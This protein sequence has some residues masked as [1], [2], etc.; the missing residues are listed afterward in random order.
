MRPS[1]GAVAFTAASAILLL[2]ALGAALCVVLLVVTPGDLAA[3]RDLPRNTWWFL[4]RDASG[5]P[6]AAVWRI[7]AAVIA[8]L[9]S[10]AAALRA[11]SVYRRTSSPVIPFVMMFLLSLGLECLRAGNA[12]LFVANGSISLSVLLTRVVYWGR[13]VGLFALLLA[14]LYC[15]DL[16]YTRFT[17][18]GGLAM[19][20]SFAMAAY[21][22]MDRTMFLA[23]LTW[24][25]GDEQ[26][27]WFLNV[28]LEALAVLTCAAAA[29]M[30]R[31]AVTLRFAAAMALFVVTRE[32]EFFAVQ[33]VP[34]AVG[35]AAQAA[36]VFLCLSPWEGGARSI[37]RRPA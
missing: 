8:S 9:I 19:L 22:P 10:F 29:A 3:L 30:R 28:A 23:Q 6:L 4:Y 27:V 37:P 17:V 33:P 36:A 11:Y 1:P 35:L 34:A 25:L 15:L 32:V 20:V 31:D 18:L 13:F 7:G 26:G 12:L 24:R 2:L 14:G 16:T 5:S 21:I